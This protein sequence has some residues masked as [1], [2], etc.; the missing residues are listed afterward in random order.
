MTTKIED[1]EDIYMGS[2]CAK[3]QQ[4]R[5]IPTKC[6]SMTP[7]FTPLVLRS[8]CQVLVVR[9]D[10]S[11]LKKHKTSDFMLFMALPQMYV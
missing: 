7:S 1:H 3:Q 5:W 9:S 4:N 11:A 8:L 10:I 6:H 2:Q